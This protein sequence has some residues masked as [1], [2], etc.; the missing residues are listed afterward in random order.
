VPEETATLSADIRF[1]QEGHLVA[2]LEGLEM[3]RVKRDAHGV[4]ARA[5]QVDLRGRLGEKPAR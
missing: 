5:C 3:R 2:T 4:H 1:S